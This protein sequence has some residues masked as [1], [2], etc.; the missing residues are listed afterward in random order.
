MTSTLLEQ[1]KQWWPVQ[2][3]GVASEP[4]GALMQAERVAT[5]NDS[6][7][8]K[9]NAA[10]S[11]VSHNT[12]SNVPARNRRDDAIRDDCSTVREGRQSL[13]S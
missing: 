8:Q 11:A 6:P 5:E 7:L 10:K 9:P 3:D 12:S 13:R 1:Q 4:S 2:H